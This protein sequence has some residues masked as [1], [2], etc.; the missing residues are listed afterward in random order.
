MDP[1]HPCILQLRFFP[2]ILPVLNP[3]GHQEQGRSPHGTHSALF[4]IPSRCCGAGPIHRQVLLGVGV[5]GPAG[6]PASTAT[7]AWASFL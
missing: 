3:K 1:G 4:A 2:V 6:P 5:V 7:R